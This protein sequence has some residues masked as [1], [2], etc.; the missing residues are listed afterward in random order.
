MSRT[1][2]LILAAGGSSRLGYPK[3]LVNWHGRPLI[4]GVVSAVSSWPVATV[5]VVL[6]A[7]SEEILEAAEFGDSVVL[8]NPDW[9]EGVASSLRIGLDHI[10]R[11]PGIDSV[12]V[13]LGDQPG[14][15]PEVP[16]ALIE[17]MERTG[18]QAV[19]PKYRYQRGN[20]VLLGRALWPRLLSMEGDIGARRILQSHPEWVEEV[21]IDHLEPRDVDT[22][23]D[24]AD[25]DASS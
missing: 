9:E 7:S 6:G 3:Q 15:P 16:G 4:E 2:A 12:I 1:A 13:A 14:V 18:R 19:V 22:P 25:L 20:P 23:S 17:A 21:R 11:I 24:V 5:V 10:T 8:L